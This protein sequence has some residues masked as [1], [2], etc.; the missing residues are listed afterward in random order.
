MPAA[1]G[2]LG[3]AN[4]WYKLGFDHLWT[5]NAM[6]EEIQILPAPVYLA[7]KFEAFNSR[8]PD[9]RTSHDFED[10]IYILDNRISLVSEIRQAHPDVSAFL[11]FEF[12]KIMQSPFL[13][14]IL[15]AHIHP[16][17]FD[18]RFPFVIGKMGEIVG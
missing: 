11:Q 10:I 14:E 1:D 12:N 16:L 17:V 5:A 7:T 13:E 15:A 9:Y 4:K 18:D 3:P 2:P 8:G 6:D